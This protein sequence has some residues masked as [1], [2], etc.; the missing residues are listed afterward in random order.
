MDLLGHLHCDVLN[1]EKFLF[2]GVEMRVR[3]IRS[4]DVFCLMDYENVN[5]KVCLLA[6]SLRVRL[7]KMLRR[8]SFSSFQSTCERDR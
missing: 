7:P 3:L 4:K 1:Q 8:S 2:N 5:V 6:A